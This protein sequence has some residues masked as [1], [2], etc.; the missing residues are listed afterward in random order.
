MCTVQLT[1]VFTLIYISDIINQLILGQTTTLNNIISAF[2]PYSRIFSIGK[3]SV[4]QKFRKIPNNK[5]FNFQSG[6]VT[7]IQN[8]F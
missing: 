4:N 5:L 6:D 7:K 8:Q 2:L 3:I 1:L